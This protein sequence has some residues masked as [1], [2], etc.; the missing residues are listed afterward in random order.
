MAW[1]KERSI[2]CHGK[3]MTKP[4]SQ[5]GIGFRDLRGFNQALLAK[6]A[7]RLIEYP[8]SLCARLLKAKYY[9]SGHLIDTAF[10]QNSSQCW[11]GIVHGLDLL[12]QGTIWRINNG[13]KVKIW[14]D[15]WIPRGSLKTMGKASRNRWKWV[16]DLIEPTTKMW[17][18]DLIR[19]IFYPPDAEHILQIKLP[20]FSG[21]DYLAWH[22]EK[23]G[24][25]TVKSAYRL[26]MDRKGRNNV[27][28]VGNKNAGERELWNMIWKA[29]VPPKVR[30]FGWKLATN[31][32]G[33]QDL[34]C[35]KTWIISLHVKSAGWNLKLII[36]PW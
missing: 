1:I 29:D 22:Y 9:P 11:Q 10:I 17:N 34:R 32:L 31:T 4:K 21:E 33:V 30:V 24:L 7:W 36:M 20:F 2:G 13:T 18:E 5:G 8:N 14:R 12:K 23:S 16:S 19:K 28:G 3:K 35:K 26:A 6:Q 25:F 27:A 15:N